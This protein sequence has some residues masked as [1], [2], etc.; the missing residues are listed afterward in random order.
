MLS[1]ANH[2]FPSMKL[3]PKDI[4][5]SFSG[6]RPIVSSDTS[7]PSKAS[8]V[9]VLLQ[10]N[11]LLTITGGKLTTFRQMAYEVMRKI[12]QRL[13]LPKRLDRKA[14]VFHENIDI[15]INDISNELIHRWQGRLGSVCLILFQASRK[16]NKPSFPKPKPVGRKSVGLP[17]M[18]ASFTWMICYCEESAWD[19]YCQRRDAT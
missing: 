12:Q 4:I 5:S 13:S 19:C 15:D 11:G 7:K 6:L 17:E 8:R 14:R 1:A 3:T 9:H 18:S 2:F 10:E 16:V